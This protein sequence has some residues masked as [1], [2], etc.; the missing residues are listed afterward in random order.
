MSKREALLWYFGLWSVALA[1]C[2]MATLP[3]GG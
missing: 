1:I 3:T 2:W